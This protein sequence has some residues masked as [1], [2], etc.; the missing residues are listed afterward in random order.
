MA[1]TRPKQ[2]KKQKP[3]EIEQPFEEKSG[4]AARRKEFITFLK[5]D[6]PKKSNVIIP[7]SP[8]NTRPD[9]LQTGDK[10]AALLEY[11]NTLECKITI[12]VSDIPHRHNSDIDYALDASLSNIDKNDN[13]IKKLLAQTDEF[14]DANRTILQNVE[15]ISWLDY[16]KQRQSAIKKNQEFLEKTLQNPRDDAPEALCLFIRENAKKYS[17][18]Q[19]HNL[20]KG[21]SK[22][23]IESEINRLFNNS[24]KLQVE[25]MSVFAELSK[26]F[27]AHI[28]PDHTLAFQK[29]YIVFKSLLSDSSNS[30]D[31]LLVDFYFKNVVPQHTSKEITSICGNYYN[32]RSSS[33]KLHPSTQMVK[34]MLT[35]CAGQVPQKDLEVLL[36]HFILILAAQ[37]SPQKAKEQVLQIAGIDPESIE[38]TTYKITSPFFTF[39][40]DRLFPSNS[41]QLELDPEATPDSHAIPIP[42]TKSLNLFSDSNAPQ[43]RHGQ[44]QSTMGS[45]NT[46]TGL[47]SL[48]A[49]SGPASG[50]TLYGGGANNLFGTSTS[51]TLATSPPKG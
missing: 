34:E 6:I 50:A 24:I 1:T 51:S 46:P 3:K 38:D 13:V 14:L 49:N 2:E 28:Y 11:L 44:E 8:N 31:C 36:R 41:K 25:E 9:G 16:A 27:K 18:A 37:S 43:N 30:H 29:A 17:D 23:E 21:K 10:L 7:I 35:M 32:E 26:E 42:N 5:T 47:L 22:T 33:D 20:P 12:M 48:F 45:N 39:N 40:P 19:I 15:V 4:V